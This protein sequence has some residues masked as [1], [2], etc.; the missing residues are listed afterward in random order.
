M[1]RFHISRRGFV[2]GAAATAG[3]LATDAFAI[4]GRRVHITRHDVEIPGLPDALDGVRIA[5]VTDMHLHG[6]LHA[7]ARATMELIQEEKPEITLLTGDACERQRY[8]SDV[9]TFTRE[10]RGSVATLALMGNWEYFV[11][12][13]PMQAKAAYGAAGAEL[14]VNQSRRIEIGNASLSIIGLDDPVRGTP[15]LYQTLKYAQPAD[16]AIWAYHAP[17]FADLIPPGLAPSP[18]FM[19]SGH[20]HGGQIRLPFVPPFLPFGS[21]RF[22]QGWYRDTLAPLYVSRGI[23]TTTIRARF[24]CPAELPIFVLKRST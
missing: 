8:L 12:I 9:T 3:A 18:T 4:E 6:G 11:D 20:T 10:C 2:L 13:T 17:G 21:G 15:N 19:L 24:R 7:A 14:L 1:R 5:Q 16:I 23:G 22:V